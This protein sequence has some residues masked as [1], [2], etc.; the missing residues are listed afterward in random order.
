MKAKK[1]DVMKVWNILEAFSQGAHP[2]KFS[3]FIAKNKSKLKSEVDILKTLA[4]PPEKYQEYDAKRANLAKK[5][6]DVDDAG[7]PIIKGNVYSITENIEEF[8]KEVDLLKNEYEEHIKAFDE[9]FGQ[10]QEILKEELE[11]DGHAIKVEDLPQKI[12]PVLIELF[13]NTGLLAD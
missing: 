9:Q 12:E 5:Y 4:T 3:Y 8:N 6:A 7:K 11:F 2:I 13:M 1:S 10:Y